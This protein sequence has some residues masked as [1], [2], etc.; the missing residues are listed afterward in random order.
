MATSLGKHVISNL[1]VV[2]KEVG[3]QPNRCQ[4]MLG[5]GLLWNPMIVGFAA[6]LC[7]IFRARACRHLIEPFCTEGK[8]DPS[9][10][11]Q[12]TLYVYDQQRTTHIFWGEMPTLGPVSYP[13]TCM[14]VLN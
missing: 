9:G 1:N 5:K 14:M 2:S 8:E 6:A 4:P 12:V 13:A 7:Y 11:D 10:N 3:S